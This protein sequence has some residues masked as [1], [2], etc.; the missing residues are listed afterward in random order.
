MVALPRFARH[1]PYEEESAFARDV[2]AGL[3]ARPKR[4]APK[5]FYDEMGSKLFE[6]IT[7]LAEY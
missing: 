1:E 7:E 3:T 5:Y 4:L 2:I 6:Q